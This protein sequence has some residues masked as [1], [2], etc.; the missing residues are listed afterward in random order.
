[1]LSGPKLFIIKGFHCSLYRQICV[2]AL[3]VCAA[4]LWVSGCS[5]QLLFT[6]RLASLSGNDVNGAFLQLTLNSSEQ[7]IQR[8]TNVLLIAKG[9]REG[10]GRGEQTKRVDREE[11]WEG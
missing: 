6:E 4:H 7:H 8:L 10:G 11:G 2:T 5:E 9:G 3:C 1:M